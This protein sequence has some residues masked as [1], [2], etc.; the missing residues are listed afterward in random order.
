MKQYHFE[1]VLYMKKGRIL[2]VKNEKRESIGHIKKED[3]SE[4]EKGGSFS[5]TFNDETTVVM[6]IEK[7]SL[8]NFLVATY[9]IKMEGMT[10]ALKD[11]AG[12]SLLYF[13]VLGEID[14][15]NI[16]IY[17]NWSEEVEVKIDGTHIATIKPDNFSFKTRILIDDNF[18]ESCTFFAVTVLIYFMYKIYK[19]ETA[20]IENL[21]SD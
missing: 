2:H 10:Y 21:I 20:F 3:I 5:L 1:D 18:D 17:E 7:R 12:N 4:C 16:Q 13:C 11:K 8:K 14:G 15:K 9:I 19:K 6:G